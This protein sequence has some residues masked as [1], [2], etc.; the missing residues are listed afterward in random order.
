MERNR[1]LCARRSA[2]Q[3]VTWHYVV[4]WV[5]LLLTQALFYCVNGDLFVV[6]SGEGWRIVAGNLKF[7]ASAAA[8]FFMPSLAVCLVLAW[9]P[10]KGRASRALFRWVYG[11]SMAAMLAANVAEMP[12]YRWTFRRMTWDIFSYMGTNFDGAWGTLLWQFVRDFWPYFLLFFALLLLLLWVSGRVRWKPMSDAPA[13]WWQRA[14]AIVL[15]VG[16]DVVLVRGGIVTQSKPLRVVDA[17]RYASGTNAALVVNTPFSIVR[18][19]GH[20]NA[21]R[22]LHYFE[23]ERHLEAVYTPVHL[24]RH[25]AAGAPLRGRNVVLVILESF[26]EEYLLAGYTPFL[27]SLAHCGTYLHGLANGKRSIESLPSLLCGIPSLME[28]AFITSPY[29]QDRVCALPSLLRQAGYATAFYHGAYNGSMNF[30]SYAAGIGV[31]R[32]YGMDEYNEQEAR[33]GDYDGTWGIFDEPFLQYAARSLCGTPQP[34]FAAIYTISSH[35]PYTVPT[36]YAGRFPKGPVPILE[37]VGYADHALR[38]FFAAAAQ[39]PWYANTL[40][41]IT[42][43]HAAQPMAARYRTGMGQFAVPFVFFCP[44]GGLPALDTARHMQHA[45]LLPTLVDLLGVPDTT[46]AFGCS[47]FDTVA[48]FH[49]AYTGNAYQ[50]ARKGRVV[51]YDGARF[52]AYGDEMLSQPVPSRGEDTIFFRALLQQYNNRLIDNRLSSER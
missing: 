1:C 34:F 35:H 33:P 4:A 25:L 13:P 14:T 50:L 6:A 30:D 32:Y 21:L 27:D 16:I 44:G 20:A 37:S 22:R 19:M 47:L 17:G 41:V 43:D 48:P 45:D 23:D 51:R 52:S 3:V 49:V 29:A 28:E 36:Q 39:M 46:V 42:A 10:H 24:P 15:A 31:E 26:G 9:I 40:F 11:V 12:Y 18:T 38:R 8:L 5:M 2:W 7:A